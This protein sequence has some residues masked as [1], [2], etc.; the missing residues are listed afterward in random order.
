MSSF[1]WTYALLKIHDSNIMYSVRL[2]SGHYMF[3]F[4]KGNQTCE[5]H[6]R[7]WYPMYGIAASSDSDD[8][9]D[10]GSCE[11]RSLKDR[12]EFSVAERQRYTDFDRESYSL[13]VTRLLPES[14]VVA[15]RFSPAFL[16]RGSMAHR[17]PSWEA[18]R[19]S[20]KFLAWKLRWQSS[21][22]RLRKYRGFHGL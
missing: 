3:S 19:V 5:H 21:S 9:L 6:V 12:A 8:E 22:A 4:T 11:H 13:S 7:V 14:K 1:N 20:R 18:R 15:R 16:N 2:G 17:G 10:R